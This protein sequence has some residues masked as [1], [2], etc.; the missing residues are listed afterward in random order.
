MITIKKVQILNFRS[1]QGKHNKMNT[2]SQINVLVGKNNVGKTNALRAIYLFF[3]P[4]NYDYKIDRNMGKEITRGSSKD[5]IIHIDFEDTEIIRGEIVKYKI[6]CNFNKL[7]KYKVTSRNSDVLTK[8]NTEKSITNYLDAH[9]KCVYLSTTDEN[10]AE[11]SDRLVN[12]MILKY[13]QAQSR[14][15]RQ[16]VTDFQKQ[17]DSLLETFND[18]IKLIEENLG[19]EFN[20]LEGVGTKPRLEISKNNDISEFLMNNIKL[21]LDDSYAQSITSK[22]AGIQRASLII[23][24]IFLLNEI[25][26]K[27]NK[28][29]LL[30]EPEAFL[31]PLLIKQIKR[32]LEE[33]ARYSNNLQMFMTSHS[34]ELLSEVNNPMYNFY[35]VVQNI[36]DR[37]FARSKNEIDTLKYSVFEDFDDVTKNKVLRNYGLLDEIDD[38][39]YVIVCEGQTDKNYLSELLKDNSLVPQIRYGRYSNENHKLD[40]KY[41]Y[42]GKAANAIPPILSYLDRVSKIKREVL[43]LFDGDDEGNKVSSKI[44]KN[45]FPNL[46]IKKIV[47]QKN[48]EIE[49]MVFDKEEF[50]SLVLENFQEV[51]DKKE[52]FIQAFIDMQPNESLISKTEKFLQLY[53]INLNIM[54]IK[55]VLSQDLS[56][57]TLQ[58]KWL[59]EIINDFFSF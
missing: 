18:N 56:N 3:N 21:K 14:Q 34:R 44:K 52:L 8:L 24:T 51:Y 26:G 45:D 16:V 41:N 36:E 59:D 5:P 37:T 27:Q 1:Y 31:Y 46:K 57:K 17:Y 40:L 42:I 38:Y 43:I 30:D 4:N 54:Q 47:Y 50:I 19:N 10:I 49:D 9:F 13:F 2:I 58:R 39:E 28:I 12:D 11:Q 35:N 20:T 23:L 48:K 55:Y 22:G 29:I 53:N 25:Y 33:K 6:T 15:I 32:V 7:Q